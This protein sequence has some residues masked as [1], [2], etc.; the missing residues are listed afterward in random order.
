MGQQLQHAF[1]C[2]IRLV[3]QQ[4]LR[5][6]EQRGQQRIGSVQVARLSGRQGKASRVAPRIACRMD[7]GG[8]STFAPPDALGALGPPFA[9]AAC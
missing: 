9:P 1:L 7:F 5:A 2:V 3:R 6:G 8:Q 4:R